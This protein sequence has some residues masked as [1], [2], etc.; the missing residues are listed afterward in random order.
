M[1]TLEELRRASAS[2][3]DPRIAV[4]MGQ[5]CCRVPITEHV[6]VAALD[7]VPSPVGPTIRMVSFELKELI[8]D[9][10]RQWRWTTLDE[11]II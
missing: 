5:R 10:V 11:V 6:P 9:G 2:L 1:I 3:P 4:E 7:D 8:K